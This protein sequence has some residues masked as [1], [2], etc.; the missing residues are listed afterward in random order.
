M[1]PGRGSPLLYD[2]SPEL[3]GEERMPAGLFYVGYLLLGAGLFL[4]AA[5]AIATALAGKAEQEGQ[6]WSTI[7]F[8]TVA[9]AGLV[10]VSGVATL[11]AFLP[12]ALWTFGWGDTPAD[13]STG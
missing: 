1:A 2:A 12:A 7:G 10:M 8:G 6:P 4:L 13:H 3:V 9:W 11:N 5:A